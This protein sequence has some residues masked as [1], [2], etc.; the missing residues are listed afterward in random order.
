MTYDDVVL[1]AGEKME[2]S[3]EVFKES[4][5]GI[6]TGRATPALLENVRVDYYGT[7]TR[8]KELAIISTPDPRTLVVKPYDPSS[9]G[10]IE[11]AIQKSDT[12]LTPSSDG[13]FIRL[14]VPPLSGERRKQLV[15]QVKDLAEESKVSIRNVRRDAN[16]QAETLEKDGGIGEDELHKLKDEI[17]EL[18]KDHEKKIGDLF[19]AKKKEILEE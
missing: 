5:R 15:N 7:Q 14:S 4:I 11:K 12:G 9:I 3:V 13:K 16:K 2:K 18:V 19:E 8:L 10:E 1:E 17:Q 6:R